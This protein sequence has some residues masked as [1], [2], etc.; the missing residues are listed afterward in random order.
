MNKK[1]LTGKTFGKLAIINE[2]TMRNKTNGTVIWKCI[3]SC[4]NTAYVSSSDLGRTIN[5]CG[6]CYQGQYIEK[7]DFMVGRTTDGQEYYFDKEDIELIKTYTWFNANGY[8][9]AAPTKNKIWMHRLIMNTP[10]NFHTDH[11]NGKRNDN[12]KCNLRQATPQQNRWN[13]KPNKYSYSSLKG[14]SWDKR[15]KRFIACICVNNKK[16]NLGSFTD[17]NLAAL[18]Y[19]EAAKKYFGKYAYLNFA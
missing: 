7:D 14:V 19:N 18:T 13:S 10:K 4:G 12:R 16:I 1:D 11:I 6:K 17:K 9:M 5:S 15:G 2:T 3:C 8:V